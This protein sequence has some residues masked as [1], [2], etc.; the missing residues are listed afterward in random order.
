MN[1]LKNRS[2]LKL[3]VLRR[4]RL[5]LSSILRPSLR[6]KR[7]KVFHTVYVRAKM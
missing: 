6:I 1:S 5:I 3:L 7:K 2:F 4:R